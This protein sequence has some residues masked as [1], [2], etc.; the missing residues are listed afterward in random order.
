MSEKRHR[1]QQRRQRRKA[2]AAARSRKRDIT[3]D[4]LLAE[5]AELAAQSIEEV[6]DGLDAECWA[7]SLLTTWQ[8]E[9]QLVSLFAG[10]LE[11]LGTPSALT[12]L[13]A[14]NAVGAPGAGAAA[15][16]LAA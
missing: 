16:R 13:R 15:D 2:Q 6:T 12:A 10:A 1:N 3:L 9:A 8:R 7:S 4:R 11:A 14:L 5:L